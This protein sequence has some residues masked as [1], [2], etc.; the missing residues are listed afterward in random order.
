MS[1]LDYGRS[2]IK[3][4]EKVCFWGVKVKS[5]QKINFLSEASISTKTN[6]HADAFRDI[7]GN[8]LSYNALSLNLTKFKSIAKIQRCLIV[9][10]SFKATGNNETL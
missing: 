7:T 6:F 10:P 5:E 3:L 4:F 8:E 1:G 2:L 9:P